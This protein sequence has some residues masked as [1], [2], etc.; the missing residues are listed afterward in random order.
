MNKITKRDELED[1]L[2]KLE[3]NKIAYLEV[4][5]KVGARRVGKQIEQIEMEIQLLSYNKIKQELSIY[6]NIV[7]KYPGI[8]NEVKQKLYEL[9]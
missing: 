1:K 8:L 5:D 2:Y 4:N 6:K 9:R 3:Q 7:S